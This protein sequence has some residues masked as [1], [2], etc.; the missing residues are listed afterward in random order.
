MLVAESPV[1]QILDRIQ[2]P[3]DSDPVKAVASV[4]PA[5]ES[6]PAHSEPFSASLGKSS[7]V[8]IE[9]TELV[10]E[11][12]VYLLN[13]SWQQ[14]ARA[15]DWAGILVSDPSEC[16]IRHAVVEFGRTGIEIADSAVGVAEIADCTVRTNWIGILCQSTFATVTGCTI[17]DQV[18]SGDAEPL[19]G[20]GDNASGSGI[21]CILSAQPVISH[22]TFRENQMNDVGI[23]SGGLPDLGRIG[24]R[25]SPGR[26][27]FLRP[28]GMHAIFNATANTIY[29]QMNVFTLLPGESVEDTLFDDT[30]DPSLGPIIWAPVGEPLTGVGGTS[31]QAYR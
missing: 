3:V 13:D 28:R 7:F 12:E 8:S 1:T 19:P 15:G 26:N 10:E 4:V 11:H 6:S 5:G 24:N 18:L 17:M 31:W 20:S 29:G 14:I 22:C 9:R 27:T 16:T 30:D 23:L 21:V 2:E 25:A